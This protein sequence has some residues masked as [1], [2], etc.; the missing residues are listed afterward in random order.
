M[1]FRHYLDINAGMKA[2]M[3]MMGGMPGQAPDPKKLFDAERGFNFKS[4]NIELIKQKFVPRI[5]EE[6]LIKKMKRF[7]G[8]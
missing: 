2:Q 5:L 8:K 4:E 7:T 1:V 6:D 3:G